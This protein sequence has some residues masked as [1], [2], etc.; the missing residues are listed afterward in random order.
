[1]RK[2]GLLTIFLLILS[3]FL[4][5]G[6]GGG[7]GGGGGT[8]QPSYEIPQAVKDTMVG[9]FTAFGISENDAQI[10][11]SQLTT[12]LIN[13]SID[14][15]E[16][17]NWIATIIEFY[18][19]DYGGSELKFV[20]GA[21][22]PQ[23]FPSDPRLTIFF[24]KGAIGL[25]PSTGDPLYWQP[26]SATLAL[27]DDTQNNTEGYAVYTDNLLNAYS[28]RYWSWLGPTNQEPEQQIYADLFKNQGTQIQELIWQSPCD[29]GIQWKIYKSTVKI[30]LDFIGDTF[31]TPNDSKHFQA[32]PNAPDRFK[33]IPAVFIYRSTSC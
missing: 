7:G 24:G 12:N 19:P 11:T 27:D 17:P 14:G 1:M 33:E 29:M 25:K 21:L 28:P 10:L 4:V 31:T 32:P 2:R 16:D 6:C 5:A 22:F 15:V 23:N 13:V 8:S 9:Y 18:T 3:L 20:G 26:Q 30:S